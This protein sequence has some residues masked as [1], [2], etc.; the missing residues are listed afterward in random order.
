MKSHWITYQNNRIFIADFT[1]LGTNQHALDEEGKAIKVALE[2][3]LTKSVLAITNVDGTYIN[4][5]MIN[6]FR[7][8]LADTNR[9]VKRRAVVGL[10]GFRRHFVFL[11]SKFAGNAD[12]VAFDSLDDA[13][14]WIVHD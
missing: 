12:F 2:P 9:I 8:I 13:C 1:N 10:G 5:N 7:S 11:F 6:T 14:R 3:E 4:E